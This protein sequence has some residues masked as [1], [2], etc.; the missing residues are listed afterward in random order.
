MA[1]DR[2]VYSTDAGRLNH[3]ATCGRTVNACICQRKVTAKRPDDTVRVFR[4]RKNRRGKTVT[5]ITGV[6]GHEESLLELA[7]VLKQM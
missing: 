7:R 5:V 4:D 2:L 3:C 6:P 1:D